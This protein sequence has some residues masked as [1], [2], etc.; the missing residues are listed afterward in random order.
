MRPLFV[1]LCAVMAFSNVNASKKKELFPGEKEIFQVNSSYF[2]ENPGL[3][4]VLKLAKKRAQAFKNLY[5]FIEKNNF[6]KNTK[7]LFEKEIGFIKSVRP[8]VRSDAIALKKIINIDYNIERHMTVFFYECLNK[9][10]SIYQKNNKLN[11]E[12]SFQ[13]VYEQAAYMVRRNFQDAWANM[14]RYMEQNSPEKNQ[15]KN[16]IFG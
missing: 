11:Q 13:D 8:E 2:I 7:D 3:P 10:Q 6:N 14:Y 12:K 9:L 5:K 15:F 4:D 16:K 1:L